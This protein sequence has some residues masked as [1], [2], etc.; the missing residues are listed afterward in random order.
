MKKNILY[1]FSFLFA[2]T[3]LTVVS[4]NDNDD[5]SPLPVTPVQKSKLSGL[6]EKGPF[7]NG[8]SVSVWE[9]DGALLQTGNSFSATTNNEGFFEINSA[10]EFASSYVKLSVNGFYFNEITAQQSSSQINLEA[11][12]DI[13]DKNSINANLITHLEYKR[14]L[15]LINNEKKSFAEAKKQ[16]EKELLACFL[17]TDKEIIPETASITNDNEQANILIAISSILLQSVENESAKDAKF[18]ELI[19][20]F[21]DDLEKDGEI[22]DNL[23]ELIKEA[24]YRLNYKKVK[25]NIKNRYNELGK[26]VMVGNFHYFI[27]GDGDGA[28]AD[29]DY[30]IDEENNILEPEEYFKT[31]EQ[32]KIA[33]TA[34]VSQ[35]VSRAA[36]QSYL[37]DA[38]FTHSINDNLADFSLREIYNHQIYSTNSM[39]NDLWTAYYRAITQINIVI[40]KGEK[41]EE[42]LKYKYAGMVYR[43]YCYLN[44]V[45]LWGGVPLIVMAPNIDAINYY[46]APKEDVYAFIIGELSEAEKHLP[47]EGDGVICSKYLVEALLARA[48]IRQNRFSEALSHT[49]KI[50]ESNKYQLC[51]NYNDIFRTS[52]KETFFSFPATEEES[53]AFSQLIRKGEETPMIRY[54][55]IL[56]IAA[57]AN[58]GQGNLSKAIQLINQVKARN[59][60]TLINE[61]ASTKDI[62]NALLEEYEND[63]TKEG[64][65]LSVLKRF[66]LAES[67]LQI[68]EYMTLLPIPQRVID[69]DPY[70][71]QN[72]G[73]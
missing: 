22:N 35:P 39:A 36:K 68:P 17:I 38:L 18:T 32:F 64:L 24:S 9:L 54:A 10:M 50:I 57:E 20:N 28:L 29:E 27:D 26:T 31:E 51:T 8:S 33:L 61:S 49:S 52:N 63:L 21:R 45:D 58:L 65:W 41:K 14:V 72:S 37:F 40:E 56:L 67:T 53:P 19:N 13:K 55:E 23:K 5:P 1:L 3:L 34:M 71:N 70:I 16:A 46:R 62:Q 44:M 66:S 42:F 73:Y 7:I 12:A 25:E 6:I 47:E 48:C 69:T 30:E 4:C 59:G 43:A 11:I 60:R 2:L 15:Y